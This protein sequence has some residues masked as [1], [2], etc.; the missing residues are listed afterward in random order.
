MFSYEY[1]QFLNEKVVQ[2]LPQPNVCV[3]DKI[4]FRCPICGD[5][6]KSSTK[7]RGWW[8]MRTASFYCWNCSTAMS[9]IKFLKLLSG[10]DYDAIH[11]EYIDLFLKSGHD[12]SL[13]S[14]AWTPDSNDD[15]LSVFNL[16]PILDPSMK[17]PLTERAKAY[18]KSRKVLE[19]PFL[20]EPLY[21]VTSNN[22]AEEYIL[23]PWKVNGIDAYYQVND[24]LKIRQM[25]YM[26]PKGKKKLLYGLDNI[27]PN[28]KKIFAFEGVY[29]S[30]FVKNGIATGTKSITDYQMK[31]IKERWPHHDIVVSF[32]NDLPGFSST[33][34][35]I[36]TGRASK[37]FVWFDSKTKEKDINEKVLASNDTSMFSKPN[38]LDKMVYDSLQM[39]L[40]MISNGKWQDEKKSSKKLYAS[41]DNKKQ[42]FLLPMT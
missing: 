36:E 35:M 9:G 41:N 32:D 37:F 2:Y 38:V 13:S 39:K 21:S 8:Y 5:S 40:W 10:T 23:I 33:K 16:K 12:S 27:D 6:K 1:I 15:E 28:Y 3:G 14:V 42:A 11:K 29:D 25:K 22:N 20:R 31:L 34:K 7:K 18:L 24:F 26:F 4:N 30:L 19:A 17:K